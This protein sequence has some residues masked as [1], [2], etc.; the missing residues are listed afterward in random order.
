MNA[1]FRLLSSWIL[2][3]NTDAQ[4]WLSGRKLVRTEGGLGAPPSIM[5]LALCNLNVCKMPF[6]MFGDRQSIIVLLLM[7]IIIMR[8]V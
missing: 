1:K 3:G 7:I 2:S 6:C 5:L 4:S 8:F